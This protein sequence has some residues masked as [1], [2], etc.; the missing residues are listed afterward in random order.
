MTQLA[1]DYL[2]DAF[3]DLYVIE[4]QIA[5]IYEHMAVE[6]KEEDLVKALELQEKLNVHGFDAIEKTVGNLV[7]GLGINPENLDKELGQLSGGQRGK[8]S[9]NSA[10]A[11]TAR[12]A[13]SRQKQLDKMDVMDQRKELAKPRMSFKYKRPNSAVIVKAEQLEIGYDFA[14][15]HPLTFELREGENVL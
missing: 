13:Q 15:T 5:K 3:K 11:S 14:L 9:K 4:A 12:S 2:K 7:A 6:Y 1:G 8:Y 10:R